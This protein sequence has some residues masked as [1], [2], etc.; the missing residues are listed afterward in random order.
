[1][2]RKTGTASAAI[3]A[4]VGTS[5]AMV[6]YE[7]DAKAEMVAESVTA[8]SWLVNVRDTAIESQADHDLCAE[9][10]AHVK[11]EWKRLEERKKSV[12][13][14]LTKA[15]NEVRSW[16]RPA[17]DFYAQ[18]EVLLKANIATYHKRCA[19]QN[20]AAL[21]A[22]AQAHQAGNTEA[23]ADALASIQVPD[24]VA[25][26]GLRET[27]DF[28]ICDKSLVPMQYL[29]VDET[30]VKTAIRASTGVGKAPTPIPG[31]RFVLKTVVSS[32]AK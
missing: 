28:E 5:S 3:D 30:A 21:A 4:E 10:L 18:A 14:P 32:R 9:A 22:A 29:M 27:W 15:I 1:M 11:G 6:K 8:E 25:G 17:Q 20:Q 7:G 24:K 31:I 19:E 16:F 26:L 23:V 12:T 2:V 13:D